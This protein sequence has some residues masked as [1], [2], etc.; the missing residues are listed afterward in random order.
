MLS[1]RQAWK[2]RVHSM[3]FKRDLTLAYNL[4]EPHKIESGLA[5]LIVLHG[6][7][8]SKQNFRSISKYDSSRSAVQVHGPTGLGHLHETLERPYMQWSS[9]RVAAKETHL[10]HLAAGL[11]KS[12]RLTARSSTRLLIDGY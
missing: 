7:F 9:S 10:A 5:P 11:E 2:N 8:G 12:W 3:S 4:H 6:L 1:L